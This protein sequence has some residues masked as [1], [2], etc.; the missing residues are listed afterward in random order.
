MRN[1]QKSSIMKGKSNVL[2][3]VLTMGLLLMFLNSCEDEDTKSVAIL[4]TTE[5][6]EITQSSAVSGGDI[7]DDGGTTVTT[8][9]VCWSTNETPTIDDS[10]STNGSGIGSFTADISSLAAGITYY[11]RAYAI[12]SEGVGYGNTISFKTLE[13]IDLPTLTTTDVTEIR[14]TTAVSGG[15]ITDDGGVAV[16]ARGVVWSKAEAPTI[17]DNKTEN[18]EGKGSFISNITDLDPNTTYHIRAYATNSEGTSYGNALS[19]KTLDLPTLTTTEVTEITETTAVS[20]GDITDDGGVAVTARGIVWSKEEG[21]TIEDNKTE[22]GEGKGSFIS[23]ITDL[24]PNTT[25]YIRAYATNSEGTGYG[26]QVNFTTKDMVQ[27]SVVI[28][29][30]PS[31]ASIYLDGTN[32]NKITPYTLTNVSPGNHNVRL[33]KNGYNEYNINFELEAGKSYTINAE[34]ENPEPP[35]PVFT[36]SNPQSNV[37]YSNNVLIVS[38]SIVLRDNEG[39]ITNFTGNRAVLTLNGIDQHIPVT[40]G[41][42]SQEVLLNAG[43]N[44]LQLRANSNNG[45]TGVSEEIEFYGDFAVPDIKIVLRWN[46][47]T[48]EFNSTDSEKDVDLHV[49]DSEGHHTFW[50]TT[51]EYDDEFSEYWDN[52]IPGSVLD[53]DNVWGFGPETFTLKESTSTTYTVWVNFYDGHDPSDPT[54]A[55]VEISLKGND[56]TIFGPYKFNNNC[57]FEGVESVGDPD[58]WWKVGSFTVDGGFI[59]VDSSVPFAT[60]RMNKTMTSSPKKPY[61]KSR[62]R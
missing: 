34:L 18:G 19:F 33:Y 39:V 60:K 13:P 11:V 49:F 6:S 31:G 5:I 3:Y 4:T 24:E 45:D 46:N 51:G 15:N 27:N 52:I 48:D 10:K 58:C 14:R 9:G 55:N 57:S 62:N 36:I 30:T 47:G 7:T 41:N 2:V 29:S 42:F 35:F 43:L 50:M 44:K 53:I 37:H 61:L 16:T 54:H 26:S 59:K 1:K 25:Y 22:D 20:G 12:N 32:M 38:G 23:N 17:A 21:P 28:N 8:R 40:N 56:P